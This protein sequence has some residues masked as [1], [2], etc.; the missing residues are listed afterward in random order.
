MN[1]IMM[2][3]YQQLGLMHPVVQQPTMEQLQKELLENLFKQE[4][5]YH[6]RTK[7]EL[8]RVKEELA[9]VKEELETT[10]KRKREREHN[11]RN[12]SP[13]WEED[14]AVEV[15]IPIARR[16]TLALA[17]KIRG[18]NPYWELT[19]RTRYVV[20][21]V[22]RNNL[23]HHL[24]RKLNWVGY[25]EKWHPTKDNDVFEVPFS[26]S[27]TIYKEFEEWVKCHMG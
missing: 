20:F 24:F 3:I 25:A 12:V 1:P 7:Q 26:V 22:L 8:A 2:Q 18:V 17:E 23:P 9:Q 4:Q 13:R 27:H 19:R 10:R 14:T 6:T 21:E 15:V 11:E 5:K 16:P